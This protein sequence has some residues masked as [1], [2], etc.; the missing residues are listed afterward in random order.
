LSELAAR[1]TVRYLDCG[2]T[3]AL[4]AYDGACFRRRFRSRLLLRRL[5]AGMPEPVLARLTAWSMESAP[6]RSLAR[7]VFFGRGSFPDVQ[8]WDPGIRLL[9][10]APVLPGAA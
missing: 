9:S 1:V 7:R 8:R 4:G 2:G 6:F 3:A 10:R 5:L